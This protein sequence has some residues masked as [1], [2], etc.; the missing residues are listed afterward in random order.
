MTFHHKMA[1]KSAITGGC[2]AHKH[3]RLFI[4]RFVTGC[5][6]M[7][8]ADRGARV[9]TPLAHQPVGRR[10]FLL[11]CLLPRRHGWQQVSFTPRQCPAALIAPGGLPVVRGPP[12]QGRLPRQGDLHGQAWRKSRLECGLRPHCLLQWQNQQARSPASILHLTA[13]VQTAQSLHNYCKL[14]PN[15]Y[16][17]GPKNA[18]YL[19]RTGV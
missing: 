7:S 18:C 11:V 15:S 13:R 12:G 6:V 19:L 3:R 5:A 1:P 4:K 10:G 2:G 14:F 16:R 9:Q 17:G 8:R